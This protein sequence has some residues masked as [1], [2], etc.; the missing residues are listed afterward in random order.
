MQDTIH[1]EVNCHKDKLVLGRI[2]NALGYVGPVPL[3]ESIVH[4]I[5]AQAESKSNYD[6][7]H[8]S[9]NLDDID[10][11]NRKVK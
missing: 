6:L 4:H 2:A 11:S 5:V 9:L 1:I 7:I 8:I 3:L 10:I